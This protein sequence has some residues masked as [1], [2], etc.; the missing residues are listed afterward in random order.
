MRLLRLFPLALAVLASPA[1]AQVTATLPV[2]CNASGT[3]C[4]QATPVTNP[5]GTNIGSGGGGG[6]PTG[7]AGSP[8]P[9]VVSVQGVSGGTPQNIAASSLPLPTGAATESTLS[10]ASAKLPSSL[11]A[12]TGATS[13][14]VVPNT[15]TAFPISAASLPLPTGAA[16]AAGI[17]S[18]SGQFPASLGAK[19]G[20]A[21]LS[22]VP[23][24][25]TAFPVVGNVADNAAD[26]G[27]SVKVGGV[28]LSGA[29]YTA[30]A[31]GSRVPL[32][33][34]ARGQLRSVL[35]SAGNVTTPADTGTTV[36]LIYTGLGTAATTLL[37]VSGFVWNGTNTI[38]QRGDTSGTWT[39]GRGTGNLATGQVSVT[40]AAT[41]VAAARTN[42]AKIT[43]AVGAANTCAF[44]NT[45]VTT[46]TGFP[47]QPTAGATLTL[48]TNAAVYAV[49]SATTTISYIEQ[50]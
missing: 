6:T 19:T 42:R 46:T 14:S 41:L 24:S 35:G 20:A 50:F 22:V 29:N 27:N 23:N 18:L 2:T 1:V 21:S 40:T 3:N 48:D 31:T 7:T 47:L 30:Q 8:N 26:S 34:D 25:D 45:G 9:A 32:S 5:D 12:K 13:L 49:C 39:V 36:G 17:T 28:V 15:D 16:T 33:M 10:A 4:T 44:G 11:G 37:G 43:L 38:A